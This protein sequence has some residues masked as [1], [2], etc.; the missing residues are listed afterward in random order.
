MAP[1]DALDRPRTEAER[2][3]TFLGWF[4]IGLG[5]AEALAP[6]S[7]ARLIGVNEDNNETLLRG[8]GARELASG[9]AILTTPRPTAA[10]MSRVAGDMMDLAL[11]GTAMAGRDTDK[12]KLSG[13]IAAVAGV[14]ALDVMCSQQLVGSPR[15]HSRLLD[16]QGVLHIRKSIAINSSPDE[17]YRYWRDFTNLPRFMYHLESVQ[18]HDDRRS[19]WVANAPMGRTVE[20]DAEITED[21]GN[22]IAWRALPGASVENSGAVTFDRGPGGRG[23]VVRVELEYHPPAGVTG[24]ILAKLVG[25]EPEQQI[26]DDLRRF[27]QLVELGEVVQSDSSLYTRPH[28]AQPSAQIPSE[29][30][31]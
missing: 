2:L 31:A 16:D 10:V 30:L 27:K 9:I 25:E 3:A 15:L 18:V 4:S 21:S 13:A 14:T 8:L 6:R 1:A 17:C 22:R 28:A 7:V 19:H 11:L 12:A 5:L 20:W 24:I 26:A 23:T 29:V